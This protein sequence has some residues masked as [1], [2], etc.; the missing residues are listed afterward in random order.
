MENSSRRIGR[1]A[2]CLVVVVLSMYGCPGID[3]FASRLARNMEDACV[4]V[5][6]SHL[7]SALSLQPPL[8]PRNED[9]RA[10]LTLPRQR[11][12]SR[13]ASAL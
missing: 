4:A 1:K 13:V 8:N 2:R 12:L 9:A 7:S 6:P 3:E 10:L 5:S 11:F